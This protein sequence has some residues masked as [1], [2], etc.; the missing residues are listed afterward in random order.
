VGEF[1]Q[2]IHSVYEVETGWLPASYSCFYYDSFLSLAY[3]FDWMVQHG[4]DYEESAQFR[5]QFFDQVFTG[6]T[7]FVTYTS[8]TNDRSHIS[9][10]FQNM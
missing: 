7:G 9:Y 8:G 4:Q 1:G 3:T 6:C 10:D 5:D 2:H